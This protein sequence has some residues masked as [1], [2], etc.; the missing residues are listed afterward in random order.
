MQLSGDVVATYKGLGLLPVTTVFDRYDKITR[1]LNRA[2]SGA[3]PILSRVAT[4]AGHEIHSGKSSAR[5][6]GAFTDEGCVTEDGLIFGTYMHGLFANAGMVDAL[7]G[8]LSEKKGVPYTPAGA[9]GDP[10]A[11]LARHLES[12]LD[13]ERIVALA[14]VD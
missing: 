1:Q 6:A 14:T 5:G 9:E 8:W 3:S 11:A 12:C 7:V 10:Y 4:A 13:V 2:S